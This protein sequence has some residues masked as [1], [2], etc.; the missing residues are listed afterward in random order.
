MENLISKRYFICTDIEKN[1]NKFWRIELYDNARVIT[2]FGRVGNDGQTDDKTFACQYE[3]EKYFNKKLVDKQKVRSRRDSYTEIKVL[4]ETVSSP[5]IIQSRHLSDIAVQQIKTNDESVKELIKFLSDINIHNITSSTQISYNI[6]D[7]TFKTALGIVD[8]SCIDKARSLLNEI[9]KY[10]KIGDCTNKEF[11]KIANSYLRFVPTDLGG[12]HI[13][14]RLQDVFG[15][16]DLLQKQSEIVDSLDASISATTVKTESGQIFDAQ[17]N[18]VTDQNIIQL[19]KDKI[20][21]INKK[22]ANVYTVNINSV[23]EKW[24][25]IGKN[26]ENK[27][28][29]WHGTNPA[30][31]LS[32]LKQGLIIPKNYSNGRRF[33]DGIYF[34]DKIS[35]S[36]NYAQ[37]NKRNGNNV[38][39]AFLSDVAMGKV[40]EPSYSFKGLPE[41]YNCCWAEKNSGTSQI[42]VYN[43]GQCNLLYLIE[44]I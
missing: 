4:D 37:I 25:K 19:I 40:Y 13:K 41:G 1:S 7:G 22:I 43:I 11:I 18:L 24:E 33:L 9:E 14:I 8:K 20:K 16:L 31:L 27:N 32:I 12:S 36:L 3:A 39:Y 44:F 34:S 17:L 6:N 2:T 35:M 29:L 38:Q 23:V 30:N 26:I 21:G 5:K 15:S 28:Q 10:V 42:I